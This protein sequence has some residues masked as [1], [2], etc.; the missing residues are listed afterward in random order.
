VISL[1]LKDDWREFEIMAA[2]LRKPYQLP[3]SFHP[4]DLGQARFGLRIT[5]WTFPGRTY[6]NAEE[7]DAEQ[8]EIKIISTYGS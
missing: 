7:A 3:E 5:F 2:N 6:R 1:P 8:L 4:V